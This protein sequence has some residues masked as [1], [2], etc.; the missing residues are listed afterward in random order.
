MM[1]NSFFIDPGQPGADR[2]QAGL[3]E[4]PSNFSRAAGTH[5]VTESPPLGTIARRT[6]FYSPL[7]SGILRRC[8]A[9]RASISAALRLALNDIDIL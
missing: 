5:I 9:L 3:R 4:T 1:R 7:I 2:A 6:R 8:G